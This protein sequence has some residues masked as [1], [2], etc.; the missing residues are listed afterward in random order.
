MNKIETKNCL[1]KNRKSPNNEKDLIR[2]YKYLV[3][4]GKSVRGYDV[5]CVTDKNGVRGHGLLT[6]ENNR[7]KDT[8]FHRC[9]KFV[10]DKELRNK[11]NS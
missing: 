2:A 1:A 6:S 4:N 3:T 11:S 5:S 8:S 7:S 9:K 10:S